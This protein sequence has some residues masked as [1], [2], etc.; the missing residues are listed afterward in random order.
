M[1]NRVM[2]IFETLIALAIFALWTFGGSAIQIGAEDQSADSNSAISRIER[3]RYL[4]HDVAKCTECHTPRDARGEL[5]ESRLLTGAAI[6]V[7]GPHFAKP[8]AAQSASIAG[9]G[10]YDETFVRHLLVRGVRPDGS[11]PNSPMPRFKMTKEDANAVIE[12]LRSL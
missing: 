2:S 12:Y 10:N 3:G 5:I 6:P 7:V 4:V 9:L 8:W 11:R 1:R